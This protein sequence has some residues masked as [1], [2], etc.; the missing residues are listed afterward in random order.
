[1]NI[2]EYGW[3]SYFK[4]LEE[5]HSGY[6]IEEQTLARVGI[7]NRSS[8]LLYSSFGEIQG[9]LRGKFLSSVHESDLPKVGDW[10][11]IQKLPNE[12]KAIVESVLPRN[13]K[14]S[15][16]LENNQEQIIATNIDRIFIVQ[17]LD[18]DFNLRRLERYIITA[19]SSGCDYSI[20]LNKVDLDDNP[21]EKIDEIKKI[22]PE[23]L[24]F[25]IS[26]KKSLGMAEL[27]K[28]IEPGSTVVFIGSSGVGKST[29]INNLIGSDQL[30]T[31]EVR[32]DDSKGKHTTT[33]RELI[34]L[35]NGSLLID[36][37]GI[38]ELELSATEQTVKDSFEDIKE[39]GLGCEYRDCDHDKSDGC[40]VKKA[41]A[42]GT[43]ERKRYESFLK[44]QDEK[45]NSPTES[46]SSGKARRKR[47]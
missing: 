4:K 14:L 10:V 47:N 39:L 46:L 18:N 38:R 44:L 36:T 31:Q 20:V 28:I 42:A 2:N 45:K 15:R 5:N 40:A 37:P 9:I 32:L 16:G 24:I 1:M 23:I 19:K 26:A 33:K 29:I 12:D 27:S 34:L 25:A 11:A 7:E 41:L 30:A 8:F 3:P 13:S 22:A 35:A 17:A 6:A 21:Q 43:L